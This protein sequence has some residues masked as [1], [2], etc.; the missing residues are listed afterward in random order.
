[1]GDL[2]L[3]DSKRNDPNYRNKSFFEIMSPII[4]QNNLMQ[5]VTFPTWQRVVNNNLRFSTL[6]H[7]YI[8]DP[9]QIT[10]LN[11]INPIIGDH[12]MIMFTLNEIPNPPKE[13]IK[14]NWKYY[15]KE[16][17]LQKLA[18]TTFDTSSDDVQSLW[19][20]FEMTLNPI[21]DD[22]VP[23][24]TFVNNQTIKSIKPNTKLKGKP[25]CVKDY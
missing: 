18:L 2:N 7:I 10:N 14:R 24:E 17:L 4:D 9:T 6:D 11:S 23:Y 5:I 20:H 1:M 25:I 12:H 15:S 22:L 19:N 13:T 16:K 8:K 3:D 21:I